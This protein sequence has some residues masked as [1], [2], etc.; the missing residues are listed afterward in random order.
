MYPEID[1][2]PSIGYDLAGALVRPVVVG[3]DSVLGHPSVS[4]DLLRLG[5]YGDFCY[6]TLNQTW[7]IMAFIITDIWK[8]LSVFR[9]VLIVESS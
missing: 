4:V 1:C 5:R 6:L 2:S 3:Q 8:Y 7:L 9:P